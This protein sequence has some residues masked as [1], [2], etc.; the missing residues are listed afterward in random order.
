[1]RRAL[2][3]KSR[4][5]ISITLADMG[6]VKHFESVIF[7][8]MEMFH[9]ERDYGFKR[10]RPNRSMRHSYSMFTDSMNPMYAKDFSV[11]I[12]RRFA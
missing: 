9:N 8:A 7:P 4:A 10:S 11:L 6:F 5:V 2:P 3:I 1:M 12:N